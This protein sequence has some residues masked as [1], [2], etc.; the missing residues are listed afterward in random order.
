MA[1]E[2]APR[3]LTDTAPMVRR[4][5][6]VDGRSKAAKRAKELAASFVAQL[7]KAAADGGAAALAAVRKAAELVVVAEVLRARALRGETVDLSELVKVE[8]IA[9]R[10]VRALGLDRKRGPAERGENDLAAYLAAKYGDRGDAE[11]EVD[12][13][14]SAADAGAEAVAAARDSVARENEPAATTHRPTV[15][16]QP[17]TL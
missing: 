6:R 1:M 10:A 2:L 11:H 12:E 7:G 3:S 16:R 4:I 13:D 9:D 8:G 15:K 5:V 14:D 17:T